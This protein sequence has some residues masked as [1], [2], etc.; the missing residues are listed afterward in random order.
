M[1]T[2][3]ILRRPGHPWPVL[4]AANRDEMAGRPWK[5]PA[6]HWPDRPEVVA[7]IDL[8]AG[9]TWLGIN[10]HGVAAGILNRP[11]S[12]GP[13]ADKRSR[14]EVVLEALDHADAASAA[15]AL[16]ALDVDAYK[17]FNLVIA[18][19]HE[20]FWL[21]NRAEE[22]PGR[23][24]AEP[25]GDGLS[26]VTARDVN[27]TASTRIE[28][29]L[30]RFQAAEAPDPDSGDW[31]GWEALLQARDK[32]DGVGE[33]GA[34]LVETSFG[35]GTNSSSLIA[36]PAPNDQDIRPIWRFAASPADGAKWQAIDV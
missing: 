18:D 15:E 27:D 9:G 19:N 33:D 13:A 12:L 16:G 17:A 1:C 14:G 25:L 5:P 30:P 35:F 21:R 34:M 28:L 4:I 23:I 2:L 8:E 36:L 24:E 7:G 26:M 29:Y 31:S 32:L 10:N 11:Q 3:V 22:G 6:R 20:A